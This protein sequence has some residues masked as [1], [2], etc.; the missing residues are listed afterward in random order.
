MEK[1]K[2]LSTV[3]VFII[4]YTITPI[5]RMYAAIKKRNFLIYEMSFFLSGIYGSKI[6]LNIK[7]ANADISHITIYTIVDVI[8]WFGIFYN[9]ISI[10]KGIMRRINV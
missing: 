7:V 6:F 10:I 1:T 4:K 9:F 2:C 5:G 3:T 8:C